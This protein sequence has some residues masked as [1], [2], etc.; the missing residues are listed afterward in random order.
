MVDYQLEYVLRLMDW[1]HEQKNR[2]AKAKK[3]V[4]KK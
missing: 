1:R 3:S 2:L 4:K